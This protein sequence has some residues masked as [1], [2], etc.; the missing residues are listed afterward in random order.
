ME[1]EIWKDIEGYEGIYTVSNLGRVY[2]HLKGRIREPKKM[3]KGYLHLVLTKDKKQKDVLL[4]RIVAMSFIPNAD[5]YKIYVNHKDG[6]KLNN[7]VANLEWVTNQENINHAHENGL[8]DNIKGK[9]NHFYGKVYKNNNL[10]VLDQETGIYYW[11]I[12][13]A[14]TAKNLHY[15]TL[16]ARLNGSCVNNTSLIY[17]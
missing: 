6:D 3:P 16:K 4:H 17:V 11:T 10:Y 8:Y 5:T 7:S 2:S 14:A 9:N 1:E 13:E 15:G 12:V